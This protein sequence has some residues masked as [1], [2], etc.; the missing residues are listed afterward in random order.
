[1]LFHLVSYME[2]DFSCDLTVGMSETTGYNFQ[3]NEL[4]GHKSN[5]GMSHNMSCDFNIFIKHTSCNFFQI[6]IVRIIV[7]IITGN[8]ANKQFT[9]F[10]IFIT[11]VSQEVNV[12]LQDFF[13]FGLR[14]PVRIPAGRHTSARVPA[15]G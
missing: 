2:I 5:M 1:M 8:I 13:F 4:L 7:N 6:I 14:L 10:T 15:L 3:W 9:I 12:Y 11:M